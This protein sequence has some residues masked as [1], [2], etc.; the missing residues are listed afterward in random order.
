VELKF[1]R[2]WSLLWLIA[3]C[4][5]TYAR[6]VEAQT[7]KAVS[8]STQYPRYSI[9]LEVEGH[10]HIPLNLNCVL[11]IRVNPVDPKAV[12]RDLTFDARMPEH[13]HG[14]VTKPRTTQ[15]GPNEFK[16]EGVRLHMPGKWLLE[17]RIQDS[18]GETLIASP[19]LLN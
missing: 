13:R 14:M 4:G 10:T 2:C 7:V 19:L 6:A 16:V 1:F 3:V 17:F 12:V 11:R 15:L 8:V 9:Q 5:L 18:E